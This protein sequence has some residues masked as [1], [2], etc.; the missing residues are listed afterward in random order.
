MAFEV[1]LLC[2]KCTGFFSAV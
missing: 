2:L 1:R